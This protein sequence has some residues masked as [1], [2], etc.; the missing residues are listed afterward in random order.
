MIISL[1]KY[2]KKK[3]FFCKV[4]IVYFILNSNLFA[5]KINFFEQGKKLFEEKNFLE[6]K[7]LFEKDIVFNPLSER[8]Y[9]YLAKIFN[10]DSDDEQ[11]EVN[12]NNVLLINPKNDEAIYMMILLKIKQSDY[13]ESKKFIDNFNLVCNSFCSKKDEISKKFNKIFPDNEKINN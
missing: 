11:A 9:L 13:D 7:V 8:S 4:L 5:E 3:S 12:L 6:S 10:F 2:M 1:M